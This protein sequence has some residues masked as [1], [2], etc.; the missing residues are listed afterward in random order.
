MQQPVTDLDARFS[1]QDA[2]ATD[3]KET[4]I[5]ASPARSER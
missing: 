5:S 1:D 4:R 3:W 2:V